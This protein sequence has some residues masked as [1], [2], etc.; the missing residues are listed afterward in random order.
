[1]EEIAQ[2]GTLTSAPPLPGCVFAVAADP[3]VGDQFVSDALLPQIQT[4]SVISPPPR[5]PRVKV[6]AAHRSVTFVQNTLFSGL[7]HLPPGLPYRGYVS[8]GSVDLASKLSPVQSISFL[9]M[10]LDS[11]GMSARLTDER[12]QSVL[13]CLNLFRHKTAVPLKLFQRLLGHMTAAAAVTLLGLLHMGPLQYWL[14]G[15]I[16]RWAWHHGTFRVGVTP[17]CRRLFSPLMDPAFLLAGRNC[18][19]CLE[20]LAVLLV[21]RR[22]LRTVVQLIWSR[23]GEAQVDLFASLESSHCQLFYSLTEAPLGR[24]ALAHSWPQS[25][26]KYAFPP[27]S[28]LE[29]T[30]CK[31]REDEEQVLLVAPYWPT[32]TWFA[33][34]MLL[35]AAPPWK[36]PLRKDL[37]GRAQFGT[38]IPISGTSTQAYALKWGLFADWCSSRREDPQR[39]VGVVLFFL[40]EKLERR[41]SPS[42]LKVYVA[43]IPA[44]HDAVDGLSLGKHHLIIRFLRGAR[45]LNPP[46]LHLIHFWDLSMVL[47]GLRRVPFEPL[48]SV[49]LKYLSLKTALLIALNS[50]KRVGDLHAFSVSETCLEFGPAD[51]HVTLRPRPGYVPKV[52]TNPFRDQVVNLQALPPEDAD[53]ALLCPVRAL[54]TYMDHAWSFRCY[55]QLFVCFGGQQKG[56]VVSKQ[57]LAHWVVDAITLVYQCQGKPCPLGVRA[58]STRSVPCSYALAHSAFLADICRAVG[59]ATPNTIAIFYNLRVEPVVRRVCEQVQ[60]Y[61]HC[62]MR[63]GFIALGRAAVVIARSPGRI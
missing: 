37:R 26:L 30:L 29:Q 48:A 33:D 20:L 10:K 43:A 36:I 40:Q 11:V 50:I 8:D 52:P 13:N 57:R 54:R 19:N 45:R 23:F 56:N 51:S 35:A 59:W 24:D 53:P 39:W 4:R 12:V 18:F 41:L 5:E 46:C 2:R 27:V 22:F 3:R 28:L 17:E 62:W 49:K 58:H 44:Y 63:L 55:K 15:R 7:G 42:T 9:G 34:L 16:P 61:G 21:L 25:L 14:Y 47:L 32:R 60:K 1:M 31:I 38:R 6:R